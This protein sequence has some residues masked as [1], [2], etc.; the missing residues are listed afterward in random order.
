MVAEKTFGTKLDWFFD[1]WIRGNGI[2]KYTWNYTV[3]PK[4][5]K[6][7]MI[8]NVDQKVFAGKEEL[9]GVYF[10]MP[11]P[12]RIYFDKDKNS[13]Q[14]LNI[15]KDTHVFTLLLPEKPRKVTL[16]EYNAVFADVKKK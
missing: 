3:K 2:P 13:Q 10:K 16:N 11:V 1:Q 15:N 7:E 9:E 6:Y 8:V 5:G 4:D 12:L 14:N